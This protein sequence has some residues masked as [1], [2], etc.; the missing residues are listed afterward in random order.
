LNLLSNIGRNYPPHEVMSFVIPKNLNCLC[1]GDGI[2]QCP[3][4]TLPPPRRWTRPLDGPDRQGGCSIRP[5][6][7]N[8][9]RGFG[10][11]GPCR[12]S[13]QWPPESSAPVFRQRGRPD[14]MSPVECYEAA[15]ISRPSPERSEPALREQ[16]F[17]NA[18]KT[19]SGRRDSIPRRPAWEKWQSFVLNNM[20]A[21]GVD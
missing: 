19:W 3:N 17:L 4:G 15:P 1:G 6:D 7:E 18:L 13:R 20:D 9:P 12:R 10:P 8:P 2:S 11:A 16:F 14:G 21:H 5:S